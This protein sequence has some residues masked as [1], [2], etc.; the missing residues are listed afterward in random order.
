M[1]I[2]LTDFANNKINGLAPSEY[3]LF[4]EFLEEYDGDLYNWIVGTEPTPDKYVAIVGIIT[5]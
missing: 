4:E 3:A 5:T 1:D 2:V